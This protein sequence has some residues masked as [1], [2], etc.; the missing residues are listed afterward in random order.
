[1]TEMDLPNGWWWMFCVHGIDWPAYGW[2]QTS[3]RL[4]SVCE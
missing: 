2:V 1:M 3:V 4:V